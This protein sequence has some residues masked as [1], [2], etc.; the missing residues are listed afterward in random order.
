MIKVLFVCMG[1]ICRSPTAEGVFRA[2]VARA[3]LLEQIEIDS[4]GTHDYHLGKSPDPRAQESALARGINLSGLQARMVEAGDFQRF[5]YIIAMDQENYRLLMEAC[6]PS[7]R[8]K[9]SLLMDYAPHLKV[10]EVPDPYYGGASGFERVMDMVE[11]AVE[12]LLG[13]VRERS[14]EG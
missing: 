6:P 12:G 11:E 14:S 10:A 7:D 2:A 8:D 4:A 9:I 5:D 1:N 13:H 3:G